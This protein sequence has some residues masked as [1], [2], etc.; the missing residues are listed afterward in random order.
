MLL[1]S[2]FSGT[3][4]LRQGSNLIWIARG[5]MNVHIHALRVPPFSSTGCGVSSAETCSDSGTIAAMAL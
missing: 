2:T 3:T 1:P 4:P 5:T